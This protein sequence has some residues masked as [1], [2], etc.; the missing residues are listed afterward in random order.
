[1]SSAEY[2][3]VRDDIQAQN[4]GDEVM[5][6]DSSGQT[7]HVL[8]HTA[9]AIWKLC[10]GQHTLDEISDIIFEKYPDAGSWLKDDIQTTI[11]DFRQ[12]NLLQK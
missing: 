5:L 4:I 1:M 3:R 8:N 9:Y 11:E 12:K 6:H 10:D 7:I 2:I